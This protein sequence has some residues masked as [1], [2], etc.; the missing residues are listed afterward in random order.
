MIKLFTISI[1]W[2]AFCVQSF[3]TVNIAIILCTKLVFHTFQLFDN[4]NI[5]VYKWSTDIFSNRTS[6]FFRLMGSELAM[7]DEDLEQYLK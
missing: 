7:T 4:N 3:V 6:A 1:S 2:G 5:A